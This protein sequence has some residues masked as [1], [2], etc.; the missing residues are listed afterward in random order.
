MMSSA[1]RVFV[2]SASSF[3]LRA[4][5]RSNSTASADFFGCFTGRREP[6]T[7]ARAP[8]SRARVHSITCEEYRPSRRRTAPFSPFGAFSYSATI[9]SLYSA[10]NDRRDGRGDGPPV[11]RG[12]DN[13]DTS[14][15]P[16]AAARRSSD[17]TSTRISDHALCCEPRLQAVSSDL[18]RE[19]VLR[20]SNAYP[21]THEPLPGA[22]VPRIRGRVPPRTQFRRI[23]A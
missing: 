8:A 22:G 23:P 18:G 20:A 15:L 1:V 14:P 2:S 3:A 21:P 17:D 11:E 16:L 9:A 6:V 10:L 12:P 4:R 5:S 13:G 19:G 7:P